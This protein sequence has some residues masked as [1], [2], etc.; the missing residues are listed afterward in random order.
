MKIYYY[1]FE[2]GKLVNKDELNVNLIKSFVSLSGKIRFE[3]TLNEG[4][5]IK[6]LCLDDLNTIKSGKWLEIDYVVLFSP[7]SIP[8]TDIDKIS[9]YCYGWMK[10]RLKK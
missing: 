4:G 10:D 2:C 8:E 5:K 7:C 9:V 1:R 3:V 6:Y